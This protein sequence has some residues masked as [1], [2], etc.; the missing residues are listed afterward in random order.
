MK[1]LSSLKLKSKSLKP[2]LAKDT[3][4]CMQ[5][6]IV[7]GYIGQTEYIIEKM[8]EESGLT[9]VKVVATGG[10]GRIIWQNT[11]KIDI[12]DKE[13]TLQGMRI[14]YEKNKNNK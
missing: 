9:D 10:L 6:G 8:K 7:Y 4:S 5:A 2:F 14:I 13:L 12:Y 11:D 3:I 1:Q